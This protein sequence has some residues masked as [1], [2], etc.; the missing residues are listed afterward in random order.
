MKSSWPAPAGRGLVFAKVL[1]QKWLTLLTAANKGG[2]CYAVD[3]LR[4]PDSAVVVRYGYFIY[5]GRSDPY[6]ARNCYYSCAV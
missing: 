1:H 5:H 4:N 3:N 2:E 6:S